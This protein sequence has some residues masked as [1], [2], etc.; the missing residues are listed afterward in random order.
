VRFLVRWCRIDA[1]AD[2]TGGNTPEKNGRAIIASAPRPQPF[3]SA[4][5][6]VTRRMMK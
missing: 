4:R 5:A 1:D 3:G 2:A 6:A